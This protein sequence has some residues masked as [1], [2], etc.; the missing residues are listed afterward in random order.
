MLPSHL[1]Y[2]FFEDDGTLLVIV[3]K[4]LLIEHVEV[5]MGT[6]KKHIKALGWSISDIIGIPPSICTHKIQLSDECKPSIGHQ[7]RLNPPM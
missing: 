4:D 1:R 6:L 7:M 3:A 5:M 2:V